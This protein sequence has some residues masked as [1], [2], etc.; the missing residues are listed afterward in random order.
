M[1]LAERIAKLAL[2]LGLA[3]ALSGE[4]KAGD[5]FIGARGPTNW[6]LDGRVGYSRNEKGVEA[7]TNNLILKYWD[8]DSIG[9]WAFVN[10]PYKFVSSAGESDNGIGDVSIG[11]GPRG[12]I[13]DAH[14]L[15]Y[16]SLTLPTGDSRGKIAIGNG[17]Y[18]TKIG[19]NATYLTQDKN[20]EIDASLDYNFSG[21]NKKGANPPD[22][23]S[24]GLL[25]GGKVTEKVRFATGIAGLVKEDGS[26]VVNSRSVARYTVSPSLHF[27]AVGEVGI[28]SRDI[29]RG[30][31]GGIFARYNF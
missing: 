1:K 15:P 25:G 27:E 23:F 26:H 28:Q 2:A 17:R 11:A 19:V 4:A 7:V 3:T 20:L 31:G 24:F 16:I 29:P 6:Q 14:L 8:G 18:D 12:R 21:E 5:I 30:V 13:G 10:L 9:K 22:E